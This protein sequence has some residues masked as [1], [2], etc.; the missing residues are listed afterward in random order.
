MKKLIAI[1]AALMMT[2]LPCLAIK[3]SAKNLAKASFLM[4]KAS[5]ATKKNKR[6][7]NNMVIRSRKQGCNVNIASTKNMRGNKNEINFAARDIN[8]ICKR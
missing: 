5:K 3:G 4:A 8:I 2:T 7:M 6:P 1:G